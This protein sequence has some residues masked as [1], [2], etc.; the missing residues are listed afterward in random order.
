MAM[1]I[2]MVIAIIGCVIGVVS[3]FFARK[4]KGIKDTESSSYKWGQFDQKLE[5]ISKQIEVISN[6][7]DRYDKEMDEKI[8]KAM[9]THILAYHHKE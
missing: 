9:D 1:D 6:K 3:F 2:T 8:Q 5:N 4:D 7:L